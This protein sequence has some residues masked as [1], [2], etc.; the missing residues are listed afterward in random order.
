LCCLVAAQR[1][2]GLALQPSLRHP[3]LPSIRI[4]SSPCPSPLLPMYI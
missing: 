1:S 3:T 4:A 2:L